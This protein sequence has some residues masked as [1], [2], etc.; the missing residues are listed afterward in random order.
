MTRLSQRLSKRAALF[1]FVGAMASAASVWAV[2]NPQQLPDPSRR[3]SVSVSAREGYDDNVFTS[4]TDRQGS[5]TT[6]VEPQLLVNFPQE[7]TFFG[8]RYTYDM[9]YY[10]NK[11]SNQSL[12]QSHSLDLLLSHRFSPRLA[13][14]INDS[15]RR[16]LEPELVDLSTGVPLIQRQNGD[17]WYNTLSCSLTYNLSRRWL[18]SLSQDWQRWAY[19]DAAAAQVNDLNS[20][21]TVASAIYSVSPST[22]LGINYQYGLTAYADPGPGDVRDFESHSLYLSLS[23]QFNPQLSLQL[24]GGATEGLFSDHH[25]ISPYATASLSYNYAPGSTIAAGFGYTLT[26]SSVGEYRASDTLSLSAQVAHRITP[27]CQATLNGA[28]VLSTLKN[29]NPTIP[30]DLPAETT[31]TSWRLGV[32]LSYNFTRWLA[33]D[34][35]YSHDRVNSN[36]SNWAFERNRVNAGLRLTY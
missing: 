1:G 19:D 23:H 33:A 17:Y 6:L 35:N 15:L 29:L 9:T 31:Q 12:D 16:G 3:W 14:D 30:T 2:Y 26:S 36:I 32:G 4:Q 7:Q 21:N 28:Y 20:Y 13:L 8:M 10:W 5:I 11:R 18:I 34:V 22:S 27:K 25:D 24:A